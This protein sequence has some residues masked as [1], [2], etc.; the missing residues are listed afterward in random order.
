[1]SHFNL[2]EGEQRKEKER[3]IDRLKVSEGKG[4]EREC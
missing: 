1:M 4:T 2:D 3:K